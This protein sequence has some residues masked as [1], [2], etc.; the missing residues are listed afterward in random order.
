[1]KQTSRQR[2][3]AYVAEHP[4]ANPKQIGAAAGLSPA[5]VRHH[6]RVL[7]A[8]Q[9][10]ERGASQPAS[11]YRGR[12]PDR[13]VVAR[14]SRGNNLAMLVEGLI[15][16]WPRPAQDAVGGRGP[17]PAVRALTQE[18]GRRIAG[19]NLPA[20][21]PR[22]LAGVVQALN[23]MGYRARWEAGA[24]GPRVMFGDCP[25]AQVIGKYPQLCEMDRE[26]LA[27]ST[28]YSARQTAKIEQGGGP[29]RQCVFVLEPPRH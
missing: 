10:V 7:I 15:D 21:A 11:G 28:R 2:V 12:P 23:Q 9:R 8:E 1:V 24:R 6:L 29:G 14:E 17:E 5:T 16:A 18:L 25:Y 4:D 3:F 26:A 19:T 13:Y 22:Q 27:G 20:T